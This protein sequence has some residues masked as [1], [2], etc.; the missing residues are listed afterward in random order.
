M[1]TLWP[2]VVFVIIFLLFYDVR[3]GNEE[4]KALIADCDASEK[5][6]NWRLANPD[7]YIGDI[8]LA[9]EL[10]LQRIVAYKHFLKMHPFIK[11]DG[12]TEFLYSLLDDHEEPPRD[13]DETD[14]PMPPGPHNID[15]IIKEIFDKAKVY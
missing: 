1:L 2:F 8:P 3:N 4:L 7:S 9:R 11:D 14:S 12:F 5:L 15:E 13:D 10:V 6:V